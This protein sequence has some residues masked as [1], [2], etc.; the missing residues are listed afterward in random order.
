MN[1]E[2][3]KVKFEG[4]VEFLDEKDE[5]ILTITDEKLIFKKIRDLIN[6]DYYVVKELNVKDIKILNDVPMIEY[7]N[8]KM[9]IHTFDEVFSFKCSPDVSNTITNVIRDILG[10]GFMKKVERVSGALEDGFDEVV[11]VTKGIV[12][13]VSESETFKEG[14][15]SI[16]NAF[17]GFIKSFNN[18]K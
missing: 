6:K 1:N 10:L 12:K 16:K 3:V 9:T 5:I 15:K 13:E 18:K 14:K 11:K 8:D 17:D 4:K 7:A 2:E